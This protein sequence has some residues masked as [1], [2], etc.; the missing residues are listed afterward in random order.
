MSEKPVMFESLRRSN[1]LAIGLLAAFCE[2]IYR[3]LDNFTVHNLITATDKLTAAFA[4][5]I[6]GGWTG[7]IAGTVF[8]LLL[9]K[10]LIDEEFRN[11]VFKNRQMQWSAFIS[12]SISAFST[13]FILL[14]NQLGDPSMIVALSNLLIV[15]TI[16]YDL[17]TGQADWQYLFLPSVVIITG[18]MMAGFSGS[19]L[20]TA[21]GFFYVVV[22]SNGL[23]AFSEIIEQRGVRASDS[24][25][26]FIWRFFWLALTGTILAIAVSWMRGYLSLLRATIQQGMIHLPLV[27]TTM[28][29]VFF[30]LGL[31]FY[32]KKRNSLSR[33]L[34]IILSTQI[35]LAYPITIIG[36]LLRPGLFGEITT[37]LLPIWMIWMIRIVGAILIIW[38][39]LKLER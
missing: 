32:L 25:N 36:N 19:L 17:L 11:I 23:N 35:I 20:V 18:G 22:V 16:L 21:I 29:F 27:I 9:G 2:A 5:L 39:I 8:S 34:L 24:V 37:D 1:I 14:G 30:A 38:G 33:V 10:K 6:I 26:L 12:G 4:Y 15:Y 3:A 13:L 7:F 31:K 28:F